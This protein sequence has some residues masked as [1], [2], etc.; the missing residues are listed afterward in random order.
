MLDSMQAAK[1]VPPPP[2]SDVSVIYKLRSITLEPELPV[3]YN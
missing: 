1:Q 3:C 2:L